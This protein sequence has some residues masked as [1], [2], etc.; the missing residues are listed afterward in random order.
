MEPRSCTLR[1]VTVDDVIVVTLVLC[2]LTLS[3]MYGMPIPLTL[4]LVITCMWIS[5]HG[6]LCSLGSLQEGRPH[7]SPESVEGG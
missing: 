3:F 2:P 6:Y 5:L 7:G 4:D 1:Q